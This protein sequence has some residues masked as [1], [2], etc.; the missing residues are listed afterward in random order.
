MI[1]RTSTSLLTIAAV[2]A[3]VSMVC[4]AESLPPLTH[5]VR[6]V[7]LNGQ[8]RVVGQLPAT[9]ALHLVIVLPL[10]NEAGLASFLEDLY[11]PYSGSFRQFLSVQQF[12]AKYGPTQENYDA[13]VN[14]AK[15]NG[16]TVTGTSRNRL[17]VQVTG[18]VAN[19][20]KAFHV[21]LGV[22]QHPTENRTFYAP[23]RE[24]TADLGFQLWH[25]SG[26]DNYS[27]PR[28]ALEHRDANNDGSKASIGSC[29]QSSFC[30]SD[31]RAAYYGG[32]AL[33]GSGQSLGLLEYL[34]TD[35]ADLATYFKNAGQTNNVPITLDSTDGTPV[36]C[37]ANQGC[38]DTEQTIDMTQAIGMAPG[39]S[40]LVMYI[41][42]SDTAIFNGMA[43]AN[44]LNAQLSSSW[45]W[46]P[47]DP[48]TDKPYFMEFA[49]QG[50]N[51][52]QAAGDSRAWN[53]GSQIYPAD[54]VYVTSEGGTD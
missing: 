32:T 46:S 27:I 39:L 54:D 12:T 20:E 24:P 13:V 53:S 31:M 4:N 36:S 21:T 8:A 2:L 6:A 17:N 7:T 45:T 23:D 44:P 35:L 29:P 15:A 43:T 1:R 52:F 41:G 28:S 22:F 19:V 48:D 26:L 50:Q 51:L 14:F 40:S 42:S 18:S 30:G 9:Q 38:D 49:A 16:F 25:I 33:T 34:G 5:H 11:N 3:V 10:R 37:L 47:A